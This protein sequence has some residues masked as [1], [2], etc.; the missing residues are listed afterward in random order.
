MTKIFYCVLIG[1]SLLGCQSNSTKKKTDP[2]L[3]AI[4]AKFFNLFKEKN[5][6]SLDYIFSTNKWLNQTEVTGVKKKLD[7]LVSQLGTYQGYELITEKGLGKNYILYSYLV[8]Y[9][10]QPIRFIFIYYKP[11]DKWQLQNFQFDYEF[12]TELREA[13]NAYRLP[14]NLPFDEKE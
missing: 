8:K 10:R 1:F 14:Q 12:E 7:T 11:T 4:N 13:S 3:E 2:E 9:D 6:S 5:S